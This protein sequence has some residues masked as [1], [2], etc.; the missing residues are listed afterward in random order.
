MPPN[1]PRMPP[2]CP[3]VFNRNCSVDLLFGPS[4]C[5][6]LVSFRKYLKLTMAS[7][8]RQHASRA[9]LVWQTKYYS[10]CYVKLSN[11][12]TLQ[13]SSGMPRVFQIASGG[14]PSGSRID[15]YVH[16]N[17]L[18]LENTQLN[19]LYSQPR[20]ASDKHSICSFPLVNIGTHHTLTVSVLLSFSNLCASVCLCVCAS[21]CV[22]AYARV[23]SPPAS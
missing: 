2:E 6:L 18:H 19:F 16:V 12:F 9:L 11:S 13:I 23:T 3:H 1:A 4:P 20:K 14:C 5:G 7:D 21:V 8:R 22:C 15:C 17:F 10:G